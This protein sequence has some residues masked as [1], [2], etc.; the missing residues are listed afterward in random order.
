[1]NDS[2]KIAIAMSGGVDSSVAASIIK[3]K[4]YQ[5]VGISLQLWNYSESDNRFGTC[6]SLDDL[7][8]ARRVA[9]KVGIPFYI[10]NM[11][12]KFKEEVVDYFISEYM[13]ARTPIPCTLC[14]QKLKFDEMIQKAESFGVRRV[15]PGHYA[16]IV[17]HE[18]GRLLVRRGRDRWKDQIYFLQG[19]LVCPGSIGHFAE[20][21]LQILLLDPVPAGE[22][23]AQVHYPQLYSL[24]LQESFLKMESM[25]NFP[26][27]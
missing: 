10:L 25:K 18:S 22:I 11:E 20:S 24:P 9:E 4:G 13:Q 5:A 27:N 21:T 8:D 17:K 12:K 6:C 26:V 2:N 23:Q 19:S 7:A 1:M 15:A 3:E 16:S 14:N